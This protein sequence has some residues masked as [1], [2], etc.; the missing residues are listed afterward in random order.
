MIDETEDVRRLMQAAINADPTSREAL[1][2]RHGQVW[3]TDQMCADFDA[4]GFMAPV[5]VVRRRADGVKGTL[6]FQH[7]P[8]FY[9]GFEPNRP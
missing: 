8:R 5:V 9:Y 7:H 4:I 6:L 1:E 2:A 3:D